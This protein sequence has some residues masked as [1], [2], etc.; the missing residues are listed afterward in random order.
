MFEMSSRE[1]VLA[2]L[3]HQ[4][5]DRVPRD[6]GGTAVSGVN[7]AAYRSLL[8]YLG[9]QSEP[10]VF[11]QRIRHAKI[12]EEILERFKIDTRPIFPP[13]CF[14]VGTEVQNG[15]F[16]DDYGIRRL[17]SSEE[18]HWNIVAAPLMDGELTRARIDKVADSWPDPISAHDF[19][20]IKTE[21]EYLHQETEYA[22]VLS[23][24]IGCFHQA[25]WLR[26]FDSLLMD[27]AMN[28]EESVYLLERL[29]ERWS[30]QCDE[31]LQACGSN[32]D[33]VVFI[34]DVALSNGPMM[35]RKMFEQILLPYENEIFSFLKAK[36]S[37]KILFHSDG[38]IWWHIEELVEMGVDAINPVEVAAGRMG[39][40]NNLKTIFGDHISFWG[41][42]D[43]QKVLPFGTPSDVEEEVYLRVRDLDR[44]GGYIVGSVHNILADVPP[45]NIEAMFLALDR[46]AEKFQDNE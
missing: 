2:A 15:V 40:T 34:D 4:P 25:A 11:R 37:A 39:D 20:N 5:V 32:I 6:L 42:I 28:P 8:K 35:S 7:I 17:L 44:N 24:P 22:V 31:I 43:T 41:G 45:Q 9:I 13:M 29:T 3:S 16:Q 46:I 21:S 27:F 14:T 1:R 23:L 18:G 33:V 30:T 19:E 12:H 38:D 36:T 26:G 10:E